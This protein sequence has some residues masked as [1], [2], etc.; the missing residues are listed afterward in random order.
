[1]E[2][3]NKF[4]IENDTVYLDKVFYHKEIVEDRTKVK[5]GG[6]FLIDNVNRIIT[7]YGSSTDFGPF[8][9]KHL[10]DCILNN[11]VMLYRIKNISLIYKFRINIGSEILNINY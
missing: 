8:D 4:V 5:G 9:D 3:F 6:L 10:A 7:F 11:K 1:M 2:K